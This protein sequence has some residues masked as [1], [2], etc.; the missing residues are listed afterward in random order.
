MSGA[1]LV[2]I[3]Y[4]ICRVGIWSMSGVYVVHVWQ[5]SGGPSDR[6]LTIVWRLSDKDHRTN[7]NRLAETVEYFDIFYFNSSEKWNHTGIDSDSRIELE[8]CVTEKHIPRIN[9]V[10]LDHQ[11]PGYNYL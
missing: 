1:H 6:H 4:S 7:S 10:T 3:W 9:H 5:M 8:S 2:Y 11:K